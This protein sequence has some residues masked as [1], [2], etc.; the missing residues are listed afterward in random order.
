[1]LTKLSQGFPFV[2]LRTTWTNQAVRNSAQDLIDLSM[3][4]GLYSKELLSRLVY[5]SSSEADTRKFNDIGVQTVTLTM[6]DLSVW[7]SLGARAKSEPLLFH[8][9]V[10]KLAGEE[11]FWRTCLDVLSCLVDLLH[12]DEGGQILN[13][14]WKAYFTGFETWQ[15]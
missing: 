9:T 5:V 4:K 12:I 15:W 8:I 11:R 3:E 6:K 14:L 2:G 10:A 7:E 1:M 13:F